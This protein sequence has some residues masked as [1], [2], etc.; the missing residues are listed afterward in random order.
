MPDQAATR[1]IEELEW[2]IIGLI[3]LSMVLPFL[4]SGYGH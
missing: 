2:F 1:R 3:A 4:L